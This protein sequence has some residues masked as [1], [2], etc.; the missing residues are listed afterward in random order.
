MIYAYLFGGLPIAIIL[1]LLAM[2]IISGVNAARK[3]RKEK[4]PA[5]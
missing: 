1:I 4:P 3:E 2:G 5:P